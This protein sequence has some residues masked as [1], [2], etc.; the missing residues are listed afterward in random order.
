MRI[1]FICC[2][3]FFTLYSCSEEPDPPLP[4]EEFPAENVYAGFVNETMLT[5][6]VDTLF[7]P[8]TTCKESGGFREC[9]STST[10]HCFSM[11]SGSCSLSLRL[12]FTGY[13]SWLKIL[14][15]LDD[16]LFFSK[17]PMHRDDL[18]NDTIEWTSSNEFFDYPYRDGGFEE[19]ELKYLGLKM[20]YASKTC[21]GWFEYLSVDQRSV[22]FIQYAYETE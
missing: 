9:T 22:L 12:I 16:S 13:H 21:Y 7:Q 18:I 19:G 1:T 8:T 20:V 14:S 15:S 17:Y 10:E 4:N 3:L 11:D 2:I 6:Y 5:A